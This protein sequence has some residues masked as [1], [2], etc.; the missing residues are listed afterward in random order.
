MTVNGSYVWSK[1]IGDSDTGD[2]VVYYADYRTLRNDS[3]DKQVLSYNHAGVFKVNSVYELPFGRGRAFLKN[4]AI[5]D[6]VVGGW[7][8]GGIFTAYTGAPLSITGANELNVSLAPATANQVGSLPKGSIS[9]LGNG[10]TYL[11]GL[12]IITDP[13]V[14]SFAPSL[15]ATSNLKAIASS[16]GTPLLTNATPGTL[17]S[18]ALGT[19][20]GPGAYRLDVNLI[21]RV[22][23]NEKFNAQFGIVGQNILNHEVFGA[24]TLNINSASFGRITSSAA[25]FGPRILAAQFR[26]NF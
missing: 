25:G 6:R 15:Q 4:N 16:S 20:N 14:A 17:G 2:S 5:L 18:L 10:V 12:T 22:R 1:A 21:K 24:P 13:Q 9:E 3:L 8:L 26:V 23:I 19:F 7:Q 11:N